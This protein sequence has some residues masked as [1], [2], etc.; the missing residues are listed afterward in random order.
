MAYSWY[1]ENQISWF[2]A[3]QILFI[4]YEEIHQNHHSPLQNQST[5]DNFRQ[6]DEREQHNT[7]S[8]Q[9]TIHITILC[10]KKSTM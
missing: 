2:Q 7:L 4:K 5:L 3:I 10:R 8:H 9:I 6:H 1:T